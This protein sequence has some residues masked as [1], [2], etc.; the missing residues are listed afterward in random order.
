LEL[1][2]KFVNDFGADGEWVSAFYDDSDRIVV[3]VTETGA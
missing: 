3:A 1:E 2:G